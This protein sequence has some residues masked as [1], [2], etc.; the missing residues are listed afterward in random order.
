MQDYIRNALRFN[1]KKI[2]YI[3]PSVIKIDAL[4]VISNQIWLDFS[5]GIFL[6]LSS[7]SILADASK[8]RKFCY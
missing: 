1:Q 2:N 4:S 8:Q 6:L 5:C 7:I 3:Q